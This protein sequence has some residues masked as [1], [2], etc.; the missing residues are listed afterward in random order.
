M[1]NWRFLNL[2]ISAVIALIMLLVDLTFSL[3][4]LPLLRKP[5]LL[6]L[7][8]D[9]FLNAHV[10]DYPVA[11]RLILGVLMPNILFVFALSIVLAHD[12]SLHFSYRRL[13]R[14]ILLSLLEQIK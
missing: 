7:L 12:L 6:V 10:A 11:G 13:I 1:P 5:S 3:F 4:L 2:L 9:N 14:A 8:L